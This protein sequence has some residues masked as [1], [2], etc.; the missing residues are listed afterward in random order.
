MVRA[1]L[2]LATVAAAYAATTPAPTRFPC[3]AEQATAW[4]TFLQT[5]VDASCTN[6]VDAIT[7]P[8]TLIAN[9]TSCPNGKCL[10]YFDGKLSALPQCVLNGSTTDYHAVFNTVKTKCSTPV[11]AATPNATTNNNA[12]ANVTTVPVETTDVPTTVTPTTAAPTTTKKPATTAPSSANV[13]SLS[14]A[15]VGFTMLAALA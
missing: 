15:A 9:A 7:L 1:S 14:V 4:N 8:A 3:T 5:P 13:L 12:T 6:G 10:T 11:T 2:V